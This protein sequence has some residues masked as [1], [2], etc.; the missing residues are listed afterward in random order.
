MFLTVTKQNLLSL[1]S[2][3]EIYSY[4][5]P[6]EDLTRLIISPLRPKEKN[7]SFSLFRGVS[8]EL[9]F[10]DFT[11]KKRG[12][13]IK[14]VTEYYNSKGIVLIFQQTLW[15]IVKDLNLENN[16]IEKYET[17][18]QKNNNVFKKQEIIPDIKEIQRN[19]K[20]SIKIRD[21]KKHDILFW[22]QFGIPL[23]ILKI[24]NVVPILTFYVEGEM[25]VADKHAYCYLEK[26]NNKLYY[27]IY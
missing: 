2:E 15:Q 25:F 4:Y 27:K 10:N 22:Q 1:V 8:G 7:P 11:L 16:F 3:Y 14:F 6:N 18:I 19:K 21:W 9:C 24:Y 12:D 5:I 17:N 26:Y 23:D 20:I 13:V